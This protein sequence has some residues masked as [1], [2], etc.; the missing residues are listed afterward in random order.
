MPPRAWQLEARQTLADI[1]CAANPEPVGLEAGTGA[2]KSYFLALLLRE[3]ANRKRRVPTVIVTSRTQLVHDLRWTLWML[4]DPQAATLARKYG[5]ATFDPRPPKEI[6]AAFLASPLVGRWDGHEKRAAPYTVTTYPSLA[7]C[8]EATAPGFLC[9][10]EAH[11]CAGERWAEL[12]ERV[13]WRFGMSATWFL[14]SKTRRIRPFTRIA[15]SYPAARAI[16]DGV[17]VRHRPVELTEAEAAEIRGEGGEIDPEHALAGLVRMVVRSGGIDRVGGGIVNAKNLHTGRW[18][19]EKLADREWMAALGSRPW[20]AQAVSGEDAARARRDAIADL[21]GAT[22]DAVITVDAWKEGIDVPEVRWIGLCAEDKR[23]GLVQFVGR[24][25][26]ALDADRHRLSIERHGE[27]RECLVFDPAGVLRAHG[28]THDPALGIAPPPKPRSVKA[29]TLATVA[30][31]LGALDVRGVSA[32]EVWSGAI[33]Q[34]A[35]ELS[36]PTGAPSRQPLPLPLRATLATPQDR[37]DL[38]RLLPLAQYVCGPAQTAA[39]L[40]ARRMD[41]P[42]AESKAAR[43]KRLSLSEP[44]Q[45]AIRALAEAPELPA[46]VCDDLVM[47]LLLLARCRAAKTKQI[48]AGW[49]PCPTPGQRAGLFAELAARAVVRVPAGVSLPA[50]EAGRKESETISTAPLASSGVAR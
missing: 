1:L 7:G 10:D 27:K 23:R 44:H 2:G 37:A 11:W 18:Y 40:A 22:L 25:L 33:L 35:R 19:A 34:A 43:K 21:R 29:A 6:R 39:Q 45:V 32:L 16:E 9:A 31:V 46:G 38:R 47:A 15:Y 48:R 24:G 17:I 28:L 30:A 3:L 50:L 36:Q 4:L 8:L 14:T 13:P 26:R 12:V 42:G 41:R 20:R 5:A 49:G